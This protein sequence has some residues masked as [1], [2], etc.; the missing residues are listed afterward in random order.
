MSGGVTR[1]QIIA[2]LQAAGE[3]HTAE[4]RDQERRRPVAEAILKCF[5]PP[6]VPENEI[7]QRRKS[8]GQPVASHRHCHP[9]W[10]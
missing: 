4:I 9:H 1:A 7:A 10:R 5:E 3:I 2:A 8:R 6:P